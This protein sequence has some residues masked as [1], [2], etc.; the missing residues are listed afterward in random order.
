MAVEHPDQQRRSGLEVFVAKADV[1][2][3]YGLTI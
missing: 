2:R 1:A 3:P